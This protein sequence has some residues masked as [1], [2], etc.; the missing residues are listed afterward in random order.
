M[1]IAHAATKHTLPER[2]RD[3]S[4]ARTA[5]RCAVL[6]QAQLDVQAPRS[7]RRADVPLQAVSP[8]IRPLALL[9]ASAVVLSLATVAGSAA[10]ASQSAPAASRLIDRTFLCAVARP[11]RGYPDPGVRR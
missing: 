10:V 6:G 8:R 1:P 5:L 11:P 4:L 7:L 2:P 3:L 9:L